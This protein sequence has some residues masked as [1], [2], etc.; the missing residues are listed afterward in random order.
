[1]ECVNRL[2]FESTRPEF[3]ATVFFAVYNSNARTLRYSNCGHPAP[4]LLRASGKPEL[5]EPTSIVLGAFRGSTFDD[6][7]IPFGPGDRLVAF[8]DGFSELELDGED[9]NWASDRVQRM[10]RMSVDGLAGALASL[11]VK[12]GQ[13]K[14]D[15]TVLDIRCVR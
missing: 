14:D 6:R 8:S 2:F 1:M 11:A 3:F 15:V 9:P 5:L 13:Q 12:T 7:V 10:A 4:V